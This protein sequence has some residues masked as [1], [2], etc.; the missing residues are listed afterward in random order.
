[1]TMRRAS[2]PQKFWDSRILDW[3]AGRYD[4]RRTLS[5]GPGELLASTL[6]GPTRHRQRLSIELLAPFVAGCNILELGCGTGRL[7]QH[8]LDA[9]GRKYLGIDHSPVA[10]ADARRRHAG[11][12]A[13]GRM[14]FDICP[15]TKISSAGFDIIISLGVLDWLSDIELSEL[16][17]NQGTSHF[18]HSF[19]ERR[20]NIPQ[21]GHRLCRA[22]D[23]VLY[24]DVVR[25]RY[26]TADHLVALMPPSDKARLVVYRDYKLRF[27][28]LLSSLPLRNGKPLSSS[29]AS[30]L[31]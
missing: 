8:L 13:A 7:A 11:A 27:A 20:W 25:P 26:M 3:E 24:P 14:D 6:A 15:A 28:T 4:N 17:Q 12:A 9:G 21:L 5:I 2:D 31:T 18:L 29:I 23:R 22:I 30:A 19:S 10:I 16:F 1:M